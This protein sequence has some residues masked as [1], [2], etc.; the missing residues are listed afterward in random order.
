MPSNMEIRVWQKNSLFKLL[1]LRKE[2]GG[3]KELDALIIETEAT[4]EAEDVAYVEKKI[5]QLD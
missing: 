1:K 2:T 5:K 4:M 3:S